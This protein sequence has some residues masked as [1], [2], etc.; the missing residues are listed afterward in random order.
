M[1]LKKMTIN[2]RIYKRTRTIERI[3][4]E[5]SQRF[6][7]FEKFE[8]ERF[9]IEV[10]NDIDERIYVCELVGKVEIEELANGGFKISGGDIKQL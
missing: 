6:D 4:V 2:R 8:G 3:S 5:P 10:F 1:R 7:V 9:R